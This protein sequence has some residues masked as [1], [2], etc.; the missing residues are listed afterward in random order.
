MSNDKKVIQTLYDCGI[1]HFEVA[2]ISEV[3]LCYDLFPNSTLY[4]MHP[5]KSRLA[6]RQAY[7]KYNVRHFCLDS[8]DELDKIIEETR[9]AKDLVLHVRLEIPNEYAEMPLSGKFGSDLISLPGLI[10]KVDQYASKLGI[11]FHVGSQCMNPQAYVNA[12]KSASEII[13]ISGVTLNYFNVGGGFPSIYPRMIPPS[14]DQ[15]IAAIHEAFAMIDNHEN[16]E[17]LA[18]PGR[19]L[20]AECM[21]LIVRV[22]LRKENKLY[23]NEGTYGGLFDAGVPSFIFPTR[24]I[25]DQEYNTS[26][27]ESFSFFGPTC[28]SLDYMPGPFLLPSCIKEGD[29]IEI[30]QM[31]AYAKTLSTRFNGFSS[32]EKISSVTDNPIMSMYEKTLVMDRLCAV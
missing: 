8:D 14:L 5:V 32:A 29:Y 25:S 18:E 9:G 27:Y 6:I 2:S 21:S 4:F 30:G 10:K 3:E 26:D 31:G 15:Y 24:L 17:L 22:E 20:V 16:I 12:I 19:A 1:S 7:F 11:T 28:D 13:N 23:L